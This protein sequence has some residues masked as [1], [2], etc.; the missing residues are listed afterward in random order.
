MR[1]GVK[2]LSLSSTSCMIFSP[3][4]KCLIA[5]DLVPI[6]LNGKVPDWGDETIDTPSMKPNASGTAHFSFQL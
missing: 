4:G 3:A 5:L 2:I 1:D 6:S